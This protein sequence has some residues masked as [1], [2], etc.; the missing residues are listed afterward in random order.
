LVAQENV[1]DI[2]EVERWSKGEGKLEA[3]RT[4]RMKL[5]R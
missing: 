3:F 5:E 2:E 1:V 4:I